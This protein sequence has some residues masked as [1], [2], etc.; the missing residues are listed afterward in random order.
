VILRTG[1]AISTIL[2]LLGMMGGERRLGLF[3]LG[4]LVLLVVSFAVGRA[5]L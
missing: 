1:V 3:A 5:A 4:V 2:V